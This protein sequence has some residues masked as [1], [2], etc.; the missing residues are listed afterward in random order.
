M[1]G[2]FAK[3]PYNVSRLRVRGWAALIQTVSISPFE[4]DVDHSG[5]GTWPESRVPERAARTGPGPDA[6]SFSE[7]H[8]FTRELMNERGYRLT[9]PEICSLMP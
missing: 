6:S 9:N 7:V 8:P 4:V 1:K 2:R 5:G 3:R